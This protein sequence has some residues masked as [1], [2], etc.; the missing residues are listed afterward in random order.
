MSG[1]HHQLYIGRKP[2]PIWPGVSTWPRQ[3]LART[4]PLASLKVLGGLD[5]LVRRKRSL[6]LLLTYI[7]TRCL[8]TTTTTAPRA[9]HTWYRIQESA[10]RRGISIVGREPS[11][12]RPNLAYH[13]YH[14]RGLGTLGFTQDGKS[15]RPGRLLLTSPVNPQFLV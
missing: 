2:L 7:H 9:S 8:S 1:Q 5:H 4:L 6:Q 14:L 11:W 12:C 15:Y 13:W 3:T 10:V